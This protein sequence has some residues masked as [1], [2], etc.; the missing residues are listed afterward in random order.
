VF[1]SILARAGS[2]VH[3]ARSASGSR[4]GEQPIDGD[5]KWS[6]S[7]ASA[8]RISELERI[9]AELNN[10]VNALKSRD[11]IGSDGCV[12]WNFVAVYM[13]VLPLTY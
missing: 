5:Q 8:A 11:S 1:T 3:T 4:A 13:G 9:N 7:T 10:E 6:S 12:I 2:K